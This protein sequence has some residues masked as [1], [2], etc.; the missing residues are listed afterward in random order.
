MYRRFLTYAIA[1]W[2]GFHTMVIELI[3]G[4]LISPYFG[5]SVYVWGSVIFVCMLGLAVGYLA[6]G[7]AS[8]RSPTLGKLCLVPVAIAI[9]TLPAATVADPVLNRIF[10]AIEDP[11]YGSLLACLLLFLIPVI[12]CGMVSPY[13]IRILVRDTGSSGHSAGIVYFVSTVGSSI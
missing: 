5:S 12:L 13:A 6:G 7:L 10:D 1:A 11:R 2:C 4:R 3:A 9:S 8:T